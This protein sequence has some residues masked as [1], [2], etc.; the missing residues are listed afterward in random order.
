MKGSKHIRAIMAF[1]QAADRGSFAEAARMLGVSPAAVS[2]SI[3]GLE[4]ALGVRLMNRTTRALKLTDEGK[5]FLAQARI[6]LESLDNAIDSISSSPVELTGRVRIATSKAFGQQNL[7]PALPVLQQRYPG[8]SFEIDFDDRVIDFIQDG[9]DIAIRG[10]TLTDSSLISRPVCDLNMGLVAS[11]AYLEEF[12]LPESPEE[13][14]Q[15]RLIARRFLGGK[16]SPWAFTDGKGEE[17]T[18]EPNQAVLTLSSPEA[19]VQAALAGIGIAQVALHHVWQFLQSGELKIVLRK[20][21]FAGN[22]KMA[23]QYPHRVL[24]AQRVRVT[25]EHLLVAFAAD[26]SLHHSLQEL[27][28]FEAHSLNQH[29]V[30]LQ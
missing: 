5:T 3:A 22:Y 27:S 16:L 26:Q 25:I 11:P 21:H 1:I 29:G 9:Y 20:H 17:T 12:G 2:K 18:L 15:H 8:L 14:C 28:A 7:I 19:Q 24:L 6:A 4:S 23:L 13:L 10:G 30:M